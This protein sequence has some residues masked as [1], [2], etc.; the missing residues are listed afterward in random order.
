MLN[1]IARSTTKLLRRNYTMKIKIRNKTTAIAAASNY[2]KETDLEYFEFKETDLEYSKVPY[3]Q[4]IIKARYRTEE[5]EG[6][7]AA[8]ALREGGEVPGTLYGGPRFQYGES[9]DT[10]KKVQTN[11]R[12]NV[13]VLN[14]VDLARDLR[15]HELS[16]F[17]LPFQLQIEGEAETV[18]VVPTGMQTH[19][20]TRELLAMNFLRIEPEGYK[21][22]PKVEIP[23]IYIDDD[24]CPGLKMGGYLNQAKRSLTVRIGDSDDYDKIPSRIVISLLECGANAKIKTGRIDIPK[25]CNVH[26]I[27]PPKTHLAS[28]IGRKGKAE[29]VEGEG[30]DDFTI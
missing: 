19:P 7:Y 10:N 1:T 12:R 8:Q 21:H 14:I 4:R 25:E 15:M 13:C 18:P 27:D 24:R 28:I 5:E 30:G 11:D 9:D 6:K 29:D 22:K 23:I 20:T 3:S 26:V 17:C 2:N 16:F